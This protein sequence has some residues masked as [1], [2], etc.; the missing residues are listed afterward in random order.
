[1]MSPILLMTFRVSG[2][3]TLTK[4][5]NACPY[6]RKKIEEKLTKLFT[7][8]LDSSTSSKLYFAIDDKD[9]LKL[10][11]T[12]VIHNALWYFLL[13]LSSVIQIQEECP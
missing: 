7:A 13:L 5:G 2:L 4:T 9:G 10:T 12:K 6:L 1:M 8:R 11:R 3:F